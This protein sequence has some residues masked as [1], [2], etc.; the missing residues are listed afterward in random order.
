MCTHSSL[1]NSSN[2]MVTYCAECKQ[3]QV[4]FGTTGLR[5]N[6]AEFKEFYDCIRFLEPDD[7]EGVNVKSNC[8]PIPNQK[9]FM[10]LTRPEFERLKVIMECSVASLHIDRMLNDLCISRSA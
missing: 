9:V 1:Y 10:V 2:G 7:E 4:L 8:V 3:F 5:L 6:P